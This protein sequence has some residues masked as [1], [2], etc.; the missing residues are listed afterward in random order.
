M[1]R[2][3]VF[4]GLF[5]ALLSACAEAPSPA[6]EAP[7]PKPFRE[8]LERDGSGRCLGRITTPAVVESQTAQ[9]LDSPAVTDGSGTVTQ[10]ATYRT[11]TR[12]RMLRDREETTFEAIC[13]EQLTREFLASLQ[14]ALS[15]RGRYQGTPD[16]LTDRALVE[17]VR[18][19]QT[20]L[21]GPDS[22]LLARRT[23][24]ELGLVPARSEELQSE[25]EPQ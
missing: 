25:T 14:R 2:P 23:A 7:A 11:V 1:I 24:L 19:Y 17:A 15:A 9:V 3:S 6:A 22:R 18:S 4:A 16:G 8:G 20:H 12:H 5:L 10:P 21:G 13:P